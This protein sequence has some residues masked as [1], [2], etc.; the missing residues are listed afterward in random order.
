MALPTFL[1]SVCALGFACSLSASAQ[2]IERVSDTTTGAEG[3]GTKPAISEN[4]RFVAFES[5]LQ[6]HP[7]DQNGYVD[8]YVRDLQLDQTAR[9]SQSNTVS[10]PDGG[11][12][13]PSISGDGSRVAFASTA[14]NLVAGDVN[15][16]SDVFVRDRSA[17]T[18]FLVSVD[19]SGIH[20]D[21]GSR[22][23]AISTDGR[24]VA[25]SSDALN[26][27]AGDQNGFEDIFVRDLQALTTTRVSVA[28]AGTEANGDSDDPF[29]SAD[30][31]FVVF[32][33]FASNLVAG[34][35]NNQRDVFVHDRQTGQ[36]T[37][38]SVSTSGVEAN[39]ASF[40][41]TISSDGRYVAFD[42]AA[43]TLVAG[44]TGGFSDVFVHDRATGVTR[45]VSVTS[46]GLEG[47]QNSF[48]PSG[49]STDGRWLAFSG[50]LSNLAG[51]DNGNHSD[52][53]LLDQLSGQAVCVSRAAN[54]AFGDWNSGWPFGPSLSGDGRL[55]AFGS[56]STN[57]V[58]GDTFIDEDVY[59]R[60]VGCSL[61]VVY[62][63][64]KVNSLGCTPWISLSSAPSA[65]SNV[66]ANLVTMNVRGSTT[67]LFFHRVGA[68]TALPFHGGWL[69][70][71]TPVVRHA[72]RP[73]GSGPTN[74]QGQFSESFNAYIA[75]GAD[76]ALIAGAT[77]NVQCWG[78]DPA[79]PFTDSLSD[80]VS[81]V[82]CP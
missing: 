35:T 29:L 16:V 48:Y 26:L 38:V 10:Q 42:S 49:F 56:G 24:C 4:G 11:S 20:G 46:T 44:D 28:S 60:D 78:R 67:G 2:S 12:S 52:V 50:P 34:D 31:R 41:P 59:V 81:T 76:P 66:G 62:C 68:P 3:E 63:T 37:R 27:V 18:T 71:G 77:V 64:A 74:C 53:F 82:I 36:T 73:S 75:S 7:A 14:T 40:G 43:S 45:R 47:N 51:G 9:V 80:A 72:L 6:L 39:H 69:C 19:S 21:R 32:A 5:F 57:L 33:S 30:G 1:S 15:G 70:V 65:S 13:A 23:P 61:P 8:I 54:D 22:A 55:I 58:P 79:A 25:F 17:G